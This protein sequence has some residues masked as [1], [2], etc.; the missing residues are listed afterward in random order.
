MKN[1]KKYLLES[2][3]NLPAKN[4]ELI[5]NSLI[6]ALESKYEVSITHKKVD[7][8]EANVEFDVGDFSA[9]LKVWIKPL[10][11]DTFSLSIHGYELLFDD[12]DNLH[13]VAYKNE[14]KDFKVNIVDGKIIEEQ[15][16]IKQIVELVKNVQKWTEKTSNPIAMRFINYLIIKQLKAT[17][18]EVESLFVDSTD[19]KYI[20]DVAI[21]HFANVSMQYQHVEDQK[22][23]VTITGSKAVFDQDDNFVKEIKSDIK[24]KIIIELNKGKIVNQDKIIQQVKKIAHDIAK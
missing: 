23:E 14:L 6:K 16:L 3:D 4:L 12:D 11:N 24:E 1:F 10:A 7:S 8:K 21:D 2:I 9:N 22:F 13:S 18:C 19:K 20:V 15:Q 17:G 5:I